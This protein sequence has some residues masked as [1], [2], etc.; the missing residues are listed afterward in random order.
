VQQS[1]H[2]HRCDTEV[3]FFI[4]TIHAEQFGCTI[5]KTLPRLLLLVHRV[6]VPSTG[7]GNTNGDF[8]S[9][10]FSTSIDVP[11]NFPTDEWPTLR[12]AHDA[13]HVGRN[14]EIFGGERRN[15]SRG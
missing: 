4:L 2:D 13:L 12:E 15:G 1:R 9:S 7:F 10:G 14:D 8:S 5:A 3:V 11:S 6:F